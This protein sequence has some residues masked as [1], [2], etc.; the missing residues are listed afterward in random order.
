[1]GCLLGIG[2]AVYAEGVLTTSI[3]HSIEAAGR[4]RADMLIVHHLKKSQSERILWLCEELG[5]TYELKS[6]ERDPVTILAPPELKLLHTM[7][8]APLIADGGLVLTE[9][10]AIVEYIIAKHGGS[11]LALG[12]SHPD[13]AQYL[14][15]FHFA[16]G[17]LQPTMGRNMILRRLNLAADNPVL[18]AMQGRLNRAFGLVDA[19]LGKAEYLAGRE[20]TAADIMTV[21]SLTTMRHFL[22]VDL[23]PY[24]H[25]RAYLQRIGSRD[26]YRAAMQKGDPDME[27]LLA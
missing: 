9:S 23:T 19:R 8:T 20:F 7:G 22:P 27:P 16:N 25:I 18:L 13:F 11:R 5:L 21:F 17:T 6:Y 12:P 15:W 26:A 10:G 24:L 4:R 2:L 3:S 1:M 14:S